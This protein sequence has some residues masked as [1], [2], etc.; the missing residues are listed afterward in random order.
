MDE[1]VYVKVE[2]I[3]T[4]RIGNNCITCGMQYVH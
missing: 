4:W 1:G 2:W 3:L